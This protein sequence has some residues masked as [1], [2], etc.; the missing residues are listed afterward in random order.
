MVAVELLPR[1]ISPPK[2]HFRGFEFYP[3][4]ERVSSLQP[5]VSPNGED[6]PCG[7]ISRV[8]RHKKYGTKYQMIDDYIA[9]ANRLIGGVIS[10]HSLQIGKHD[11][12]AMGAWYI[13]YENSEF[14]LGIGRDRSGYTHIELGS[15]VRRKPTAQL[16]G[17]WSM[18]HL[19]GYLDGS[20][21]HYRFKSLEEELSWVEKNE[22]KL[23]DSSFLNSDNLNQWA[24]KASR[25]L[26]E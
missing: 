11:K 23:F 15:K 20:K 25:R 16:R 10:R 12:S 22:S 2:W 14:I 21:D 19:K 7:M 4:R 8:V 3:F 26:F 24:V 17:P 1:P 18:S 6:V 5:P 9:Y 13:F